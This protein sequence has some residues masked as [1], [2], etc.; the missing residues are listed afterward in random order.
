[1]LLTPG[2]HGTLPGSG[3]VSQELTGSDPVSIHPSPF[4]G[5]RR[6]QILNVEVWS[7]L[8]DGMWLHP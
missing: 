4:L 3:S 2:G 8:G 1:M 5:P 6:R 7:D